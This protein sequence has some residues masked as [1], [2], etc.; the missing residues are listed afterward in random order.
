LLPSFVTRLIQF[1]LIGTLS[2]FFTEV[3]AGSSPLWFVNWWG[4]LVV[5]P[6]YFMHLMFFLNVA[7]RTRR[8]SVGHLYL[9]GVLIGLYESWITKVLWVGYPS[10]REPLMGTFLGIASLEF[11]VLVFFWHPVFAFVLPIF[12]F[13]ALT[14]S[15]S[16][17]QVRDKILESHFSSLRRSKQVLLLMAFFIV[18]GA[19]FLSLNTGHNAVVADAAVLGNTVLVSSLFLLARKK[20]DSFSIHSLRLGKKGL[21]FTVTY[22]FFLYTLS[23]L[24]LEPQHIPDKPLP[25]LVIVVFYA[26]MGLLI[27]LSPVDK[28]VSDRSPIPLRLFSPR[29]F[30]MFCLLLFLLTTF[31]SITPQAGNLVAFSLNLFLFAGGPIFFGF[32]VMRVFRNR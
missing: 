8:T 9:F 25:I 19:G 11:S 1:L 29:D 5:F 10:I 24:F 13:E 3:F 6:L 2:V 18:L 4:I 17:D 26:L 21:A 22:L 30:F 27:K 32:V 23:F 28:A 12:V 15:S 20:P 14:L 7:I 31:F 16:Q